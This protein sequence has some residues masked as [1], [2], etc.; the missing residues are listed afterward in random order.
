LPKRSVTI[1]KRLL[2]EKGTVFRM[3]I[4]DDLVTFLPPFQPSEST[5]HNVKATLTL[6]VDIWGIRVPVKLSVTSSGNLPWTLRMITILLNDFGQ[7]WSRGATGRFTS[8]RPQIP[9]PRT[10]RGLFVQCEGLGL[11][12]RLEVRVFLGNLKTEL[13]HTVSGL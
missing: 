2:R 8:T 6:T 11:N 1:D 7:T 5:F 3:D 9:N 12:P 10:H 13:I 4:V